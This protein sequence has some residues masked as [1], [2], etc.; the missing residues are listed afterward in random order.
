M[1]RHLAGQYDE[2]FYRRWMKGGAHGLQHFK[3]QLRQSDLLILAGQVME[4]EAMSALAQVRAEI[5][6]YIRAHETFAAALTP[7]EVEA[8][9]PAVVRGM[10]DAAARFG[11]GPMAAVAGA[12]AEH[13]GRALLPGAGD[14]IVENGGDVFACTPGLEAL[15]FRLYAGEESPFADRVDFRV[16]ARQGLGVCTSSGVV[17]PSLS[18]GR[19]DAVV[20]MARDTALADAA[21]TALA[22]QVQAP[23]DVDR[24][25][26]RV[27]SEGV[28]DGVIA[29]KGDRLGVFGDLEL[30]PA[31]RWESQEER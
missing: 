15:T 24:V 8:D 11:V 17:G 28:L 3:V 16:D 12:V 13:V 4:D 25:V 14:V 6:Q 18:L 9:S 30:I 22:N 27:R 5:E 21:A 1:S 7:L 26:D 23:A 19:A 20:A 31:A 10:A 29:C 2:R